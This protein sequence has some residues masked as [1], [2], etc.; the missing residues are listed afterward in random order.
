MTTGTGQCHDH[1][2]GQDAELAFGDRDASVL[3]PALLRPPR[4]RS[5]TLNLG[6]VELLE[7]Q[8]DNR[9]VELPGPGDAAEVGEGGRPAGG[10][11]AAG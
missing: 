5:S 8:L 1:R 2:G 4:S 10:T 11:S 6:I 7:V 3:E 9:A